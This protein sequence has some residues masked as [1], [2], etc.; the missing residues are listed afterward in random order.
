MTI[1]DILRMLIDFKNNKSI[2]GEKHDKKRTTI[3]E[4]ITQH[5]HYYKAIEKEKSF[6]FWLDKEA[7]STIMKHSFD[8]NLFSKLRGCSMDYTLLELLKT[9]NVL[10]EN[11]AQPFSLPML[12]EEGKHT[13]KAF[14]HHPWSLVHDDVHAWVT[15]EYRR[16]DSC[17]RYPFR[18]ENFFQ[19]K[20]SIATTS[21]EFIAN[22]KEWLHKKM[23]KRPLMGTIGYY[24]PDKDE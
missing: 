5:L 19:R 10:D 1:S 14:T 7:K 22:L 24:I 2:S 6:F 16:P 11:P 23:T 18:W 9:G 15:T 17:I 12:D 8:K 4:L 3:N 20:R 13:Q 21:A